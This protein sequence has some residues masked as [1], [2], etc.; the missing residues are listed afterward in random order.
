MTKTCPSIIS[1]PFPKA[2][3]PDQRVSVGLSLLSGGFLSEPPQHVTLVLLHPLDVGRSLL[4]GLL[5]GQGGRAKTKV[6]LV[7]LK[8]LQLKRERQK[9]DVSA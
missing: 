2:T 8:P 9:Q 6:A 5:H 7:L 4:Q 1:K 3:L